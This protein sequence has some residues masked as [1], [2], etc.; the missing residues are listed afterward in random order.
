MLSA[1]FPRYY[2][3]IFAICFVVTN[4]VRLIML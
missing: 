4:A 1:Y 3:F 2:G